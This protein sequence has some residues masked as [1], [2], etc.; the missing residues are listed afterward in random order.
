M[1]Q[2]TLSNIMRVTFVTDDQYN[3]R[4]F[5]MR[6]VF[7][8]MNIVLYERLR[9]GSLAIRALKAFILVYLRL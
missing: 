5:V 7:K 8:G 1:S 2:E 4:G 6:Y 9:M 3:E